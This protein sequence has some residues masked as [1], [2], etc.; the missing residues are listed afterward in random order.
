MGWLTNWKTT[1][2]GGLPALA[3]ILQQVAAAIDGNPATV[4]S[5]SVLALA[6]GTLAT[7]L[8]SKD[9]DKK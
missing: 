2:A 4:L 1:T 6:I 5:P 7:A 9:G 8:F 3:V